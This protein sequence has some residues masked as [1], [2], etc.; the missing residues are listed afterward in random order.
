M[1]SA[2]SQLGKFG[3]VSAHVGLT[4]ELP[5]DD[6]RHRMERARATLAVESAAHHFEEA[7][8]RLFADLDTAVA[9]G[10]SARRRIELA[11][12]TRAVATRQLTAEEAR[13]ATGSSTSIQVVQAEDAVR[14]A[15]LR[16][17]RARADEVQAHLRVA[18][19]GGRLIAE[20]TAHAEVPGAAQ[21]CAR[22]P[23]GHDPA[24]WRFGLF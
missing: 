12:Q 3:A 6:T 7:R 5:L 11:E 18:Q 10:V 14:S 4:L 19:L 24:T 16:L 2:L 9:S 17:A 22:P 15:E 21:S 20:V 23:P 8:Q 1:P 13:F